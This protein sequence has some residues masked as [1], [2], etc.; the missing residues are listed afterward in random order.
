MLNHQ[1]GSKEHRDGRRTFLAMGDDSEATQQIE[2]TIK[3]ITYRDCGRHVL[4]VE[5]LKPDTKRT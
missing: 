3:S 1:M 5:T 4:P 2:R